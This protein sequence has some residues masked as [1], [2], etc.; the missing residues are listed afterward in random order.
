MRGRGRDCDDPNCSCSE[1][2]GTCA[3]CAS[4][5]PTSAYSWSAQATGLA[6]NSTET[7]EDL[8]ERLVGLFCGIY[9]DHACDAD[10]RPKCG[11]LGRHIPLLSPSLVG[12][13]DLVNG[14]P[15][16]SPF[17]VHR[18]GTTESS[19]EDSRSEAFRYKQLCILGAGE[20]HADDP[21]VHKLDL[22]DATTGTITLTGDE[23]TVLDVAG[24]GATAIGAAWKAMYPGSGWFVVREG[25][26]E[27]LIVAQADDDYAVPTVDS[28]TTDGSPAVTVEASGGGDGLEPC[29]VMTFAVGF[30]RDVD[31]NAWLWSRVSIE[32]RLGFFVGRWAQGELDLET[33]WNEVGCDEFD[34]TVPMSPVWSCEQWID[35]EGTYTDYDD[36]TYCSLPTGFRV[37]GMRL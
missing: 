18:T 4:A 15:Y 33:P 32:D 5:T 1:G 11:Q 2:G 13:D 37:R 7:M 27:F 19:S 16:Y 12:A 17:C 34:E 8:C 26:D 30:A 31:D 9:A 21:A 14:D 25:A 28:H 6:T 29:L 35:E 36:G 23:T 10:G 24:L 22:G 3:A 20:V